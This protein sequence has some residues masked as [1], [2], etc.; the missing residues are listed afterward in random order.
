MLPR[1]MKTAMRI[2]LVMWCV[3]VAALAGCDGGA[4]DEVKAVFD[5]YLAALQARDGE[6]F[7][8]VIDPE[9]VKHY[10]HLVQVARSGTRVAIDRMRPSEKYSVTA[11]RSRVT[12][13]ELKGLDG[14]SYAK[15]AV[16]RGW[17][18][19]QRQD[20]EFSLGMI[21]LKKPRASAPLVVDGM[22]SKLRFEFVEVN[23]QWLVNDECIKDWW[24]AAVEERAK[25]M[26][27]SVDNLLLEMASRNSERR[28]DSRI[29]DEPPK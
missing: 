1:L 23:D 6:A 7:L 5:A 29:W 14:A 20:R 3:A 22:D 18:F 9:N 17:F 4:K 27:T 12:A 21:R 25:L 16:E 8:K 2:L 24:D 26:G 19:G 11:I 15:L 28:V 10:D 13:A